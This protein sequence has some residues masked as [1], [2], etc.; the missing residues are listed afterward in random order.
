[1]AQADTAHPIIEN[2][3]AAA[4]RR[5][6]DVFASAGRHSRLVRFLKFAIPA[7]A[8]L[9][10]GIFGGATI[11]RRELPV[12][13]SSEGVS[14]SDGRI[15]MANPKLDG[16]TGDRRPYK[17]QALRA[18]QE[19]KKNGL[20]EL[21]QITAELPFGANATA[22]IKAGGGF[23]D[24]GASLLDLAKGIELT[25]SDGMLAKLTSAHIDIGKNGLSTS[26]PVDITTDG[27]H[28]TADSMQVGEG[29]KLL[30]FEKRVRLVI[31]PKKMKT[32]GGG[33]TAQQTE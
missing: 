17:M 15:V 9:S 18:Y 2:F 14:M 22:Q 32:A 12:A 21:E 23:F 16:M 33:Q 24:N 8:L 3:H 5:G 13:L 29:G 11:F 7:V 28:I 26:E 19:V 30:V 31:D 6:E 10:A 27:A 4:N 20:V 1:M 25:T